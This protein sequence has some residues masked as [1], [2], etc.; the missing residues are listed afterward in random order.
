MTNLP[1]TGTFSV[2]ATFG[3]QGAYWARGHQG[4]DLVAANRNIYSTCNGT[5]R[6]VAYD[7]GGWGQ[8]VSIGDEQGFRHIFCHLVKG[9]VKVKAGDRVDRTTVIGTM[10]ATGN[11]TGTHLHYQLQKGDQVVDPT[12]WLGIPNRI[13]SYHSK[14]YAIKEDTDMFKDPNEIPSW[15]ADAVKQAVEKGLMVGDADGQFR[16]N[17]PIT[18][19]E[20]AVVLSRL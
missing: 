9:S 4:I 3:Q 1:V 19:A 14:D 6:L 16:P 7:A 10:G 17:D 8:Y 12:L 11:V 13:G 5:V 20:L 18:R 15:A 2:T